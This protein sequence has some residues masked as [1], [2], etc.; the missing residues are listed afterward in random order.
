MKVPMSWI[1]YTVNLVKSGS[2][3]RVSY[4]GVTIYKDGDQIKVDIKPTTEVV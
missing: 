3:D 2:V 1:V 4:R